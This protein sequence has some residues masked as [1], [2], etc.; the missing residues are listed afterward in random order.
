MEKWDAVKTYPNQNVPGSSFDLGLW[1]LKLLVFDSLI[2]DLFLTRKKYLSKRQFDTQDY[3][4]N[5]HDQLLT[6]CP[7]KISASVSIL[8]INY[9]SHTCPCL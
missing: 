4:I 8:N 2:F 3:R 7:A 5:L 6:A 9:G 1:V